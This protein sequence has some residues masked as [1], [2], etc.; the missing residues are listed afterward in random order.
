[1]NTKATHRLY[2]I[3]L[4]FITAVVLCTL[5]FLLVKKD[6]IYVYTKNLIPDSRERGIVLELKELG[7]EVKVNQ[8]P[9]KQK[10]TAL[11]FRLPHNIKE[12]MSNTKFTYNFIYNEEY[13][14]FEYENLEEMPILLTPY[15]DLYEHYMRQ[16]I[17][18]ATFVLGANQR[19]YNIINTKNKTDI[20]YYEN[21][22][23][24]TNLLSHLTL[25]GNVKFLG[26]FWNNNISPT[27]SLELIAENENK[28]L[29]K[30]KY[31]IIDNHKDNNLIPEE[32]LNASLTSTL[33]LTP[34][35]SRVYN[36]YKD[37]IVYFDNPKDIEHLISYYEQNSS[38][39]QE[40]SLRAQSITANQLSSSS[41][42]K[43]FHELLSWLKSNKI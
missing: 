21:R 26:R 27:A 22:N 33:I 9:S 14:P 1:M 39:A 32:L 41:S 25:L 30:A 13:Y 15:Q 18:S 8:K 42:A 6:T 7:Y 3:V 37:S 28:I 17:K 24:D 38:T 11:W 12:I 23:K 19:E 2:I 29:S 35:N 5:P 20:V 10:E 31:T 4:L 34:S 40:K 43:R 36:I 16:N